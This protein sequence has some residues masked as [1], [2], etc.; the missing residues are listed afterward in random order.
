MAPITSCMKEGK[1]HWTPEATA[2]FELF[3][4]TLTTAPILILSDFSATFELHSDAS[5]L[6]IGAV[7]SQQGRLIAFYSEKLA[8]ARSRYSTYDVKFY[9]IVQAIKH[10]RHYLVHRDFIIFTDHDALL[11]ID[12]QAKVSSRHASWIAYLQQFTFS[13]HHQSGKTNRVADAL[14]RRH[15]LLTSIHATVPGFASLADLYTQDSFFKRLFDDATAGISTGYTLQHGFLFKGLR[16]CVPESS[17]RL[18][19]VQELH[20]EGHIGRDRTLQLATTSYFWPSMRRD[21][22]RFVE[23]CTICQLAKGKASNAG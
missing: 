5:K 17:L 6:G 12:S 14:S 13:I 18:K 23:R 8:G 3:K 1:F 22:E 20:N 15:S 21:I 10:W 11:H 16:L 19:I 7:L 9:A 4:T 2:A